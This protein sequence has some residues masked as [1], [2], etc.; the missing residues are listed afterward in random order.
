MKVTNKHNHILH[1]F[2]TAARLVRA[3]LE[4]C[5]SRGAN[6]VIFAVLEA[7]LMSPLA[8]F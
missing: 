4:F 5:K 1:T 8:V 7:L 2:S 3:H 6:T